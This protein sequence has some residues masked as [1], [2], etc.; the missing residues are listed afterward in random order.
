MH[1]GKSRRGGGLRRTKGRKMKEKERRGLAHPTFM[2]PGR[3]N[4]RGLM[5]MVVDIVPW[6]S[7]AEQGRK[8]R[9][10]WPALLATCLQPLPLVGLLPPSLLNISWQWGSYD[11]LLDLPQAPFWHCPSLSPKA[12]HS[13]LVTMAMV[14]SI[15]LQ[16]HGLLATMKSHSTTPGARYDDSPGS[17]PA[18]LCNLSWSGLPLSWHIGANITFETMLV[19]CFRMEDSK[20]IYKNQVK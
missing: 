16:M 1:L 14:M 2:P 9:A 4:L 7:S 12:Q 3:R 20:K 18:S 8:V 19:K 5:R 10:N 17:W 13:H 11:L 6:P 15:V